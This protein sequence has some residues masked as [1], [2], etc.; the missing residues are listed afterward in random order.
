MWC[1][2]DDDDDDVMRNGEE[3]ADARALWIVR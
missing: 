3:I 2:D 1:Y